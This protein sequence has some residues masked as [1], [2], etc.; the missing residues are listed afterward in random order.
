MDATRTTGARQGIVRAHEKE[1]RDGPHGYARW[2]LERGRERYL[3]LGNKKP[4]S[5]AVQDAIYALSTRYAFVTS[6]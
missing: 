1:A 3:P 2:M 6:L 4:P 5:L